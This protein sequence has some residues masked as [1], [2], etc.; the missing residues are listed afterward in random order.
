MS[1][2]CNLDETFPKNIVEKGLPLGFI[3][4]FID[5]AYQGPSPGF[6]EHLP[7]L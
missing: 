2:E 1:E 5:E 3:G 6:L 7:I 4:V